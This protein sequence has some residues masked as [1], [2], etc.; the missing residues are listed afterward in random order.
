MLPGS[1]RDVELD[2]RF[3][4]ASFRFVFGYPDLEEIGNRR[5]NSIVPVSGRPDR[6]LVGVEG[7]LLELTTTDGEW[8]GRDA[9]DS[10]V[11]YRSDGHNA[12]RPYTYVRA[13]APLSDGG[14]QVLFGGTVNGP[15]EVLSLFE[16]W[17]GGLTIRRVPTPMGFIDPRVEQAIALAADDVLLVIKCAPGECDQIL[18]QRNRRQAAFAHDHHREPQQR[19]NQA[20]THAGNQAVHRATH[21][22]E[23]T[24]DR[25]G[26]D[27]DQRAAAVADREYPRHRMAFA[28]ERKRIEQHTQQQRATQPHR[29]GDADRTP[30]DR[31]H[32]AARALSMVTAGSSLPSQNSRNA[33]PPVDM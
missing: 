23:P 12:S 13:I 27:V 7:G 16:T 6:I 4:L 5:I 31:T 15:N 14:R 21:S 8:S 26:R 9:I 11:I 19:R 30:V 17:N 25:A 32:P 20:R 1:A 3:T 24:R 28:L 2:D 33:P 10:R 18:E 29:H 22:C